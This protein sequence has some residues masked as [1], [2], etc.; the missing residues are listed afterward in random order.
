MPTIRRMFGM[1]WQFF[2]TCT[3]VH[4]QWWRHLAAFLFV[5]L[6]GFSNFVGRNISS[7]YTFRLIAPNATWHAI[8]GGALTKQRVVGFGFEGKWLKL[9]SSFGCAGKILLKSGFW[10]WRRAFLFWRFTMILCFFKWLFKSMWY[11]YEDNLLH[12]Q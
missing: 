8:K 12:V 10:R 9:P 5:G 1:Q 7:A 11:S 6:V 3:Y 4:T 2:K